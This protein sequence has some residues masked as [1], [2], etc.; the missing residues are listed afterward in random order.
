MSNDSQDG[1]RQATTKIFKGQRSQNFGPYK[2]Q[3]GV[4]KPF[5]V[6]Y[7]SYVIVIQFTDDKLGVIT[8]VN[9]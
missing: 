8:R 5:H 6:F 1:G 2:A 7:H 9:P 3:I 4:S